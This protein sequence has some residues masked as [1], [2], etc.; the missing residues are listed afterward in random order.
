MMT[1]N[2]RIV[3]VCAAVLLGVC[4][5]AG[6]GLEMCRDRMEERIRTEAS[7]QT[8]LTPTDLEAVFDQVMAQME[9]GELSG[10][11]MAQFFALKYVELVRDSCVEDPVPVKSRS[12][13]R[14]YAE[15]TTFSQLSGDAALVGAA[16][17][18]CSALYLLH[19]STKGAEWRNRTG[20]QDPEWLSA[21]CCS[22]GGVFGV[23]CSASDH[24]IALDLSS[25]NLNGNIDPAIGR[26]IFLQNLYE[27]HFVR[28][29]GPSL[30]RHSL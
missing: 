10:T 16:S 19:Q 18:E 27:R 17:A 4:S 25:N 3:V 9:A 29:D 7:A 28:F 12:D 30:S 1:L 21:H 24:V 6:P 2:V 5:A 11:A 22:P 26:L 14:N 8:T 23:K 13:E 15:T 20:W